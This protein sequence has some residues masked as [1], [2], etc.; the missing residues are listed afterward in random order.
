MDKF[1][2]LDARLYR[3]LLGINP[4]EPK[5]LQAL[6]RETAKLPKA[7]MQISADQG[8]FMQ[9][10]VRAIGAK[11]C[12]E[13]GVFTG[14]S[15]LSVAL[16][17]PKNGKLVALD[18]SPEWT[19]I[20]RRYWKKAGVEAKIDLRLGPALASLDALLKSGKAG[21]FDFAFIDADKENYQNYFERALKLVRP[22]GIIA[23]D[24]TLWSGRV[25][26]AKSRDADTRAIRAFNQARVRDGRI[27]LA[28]LAAADGLTL[29]LKRG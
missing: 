3:Y 1:L 2:P 24:N 14:Y 8:A 20:A 23:I 21:T 9:F 26:D 11:R 28:V 17:L 22:K 18:I 5:V 10:L 19:A 7:G 29:A 6:R 4:P 16:A 12:L 15:S 27:D 13:V 25:A